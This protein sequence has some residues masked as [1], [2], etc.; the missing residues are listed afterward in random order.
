M[1]EEALS[2]EAEAVAR[3]IEAYCD[4]TADEAQLLSIRDRLDND[5][6]FA[7]ELLWTLRLR[8]LAAA[9]GARDSFEDRV[10][11]R[12][13][14]LAPSVTEE[15]VI[16]RIEKTRE[17]LPF[18]ARAARRPRLLFAAALV[19]QVLVMAALAPFLV[20]QWHPEPRPVATV[21]RAGSGEG[22]LVR[23]GERITL[24]PGLSVC[25]DDLVYSDAT[26]GA[27]L[28]WADGSRARLA[29]LSYAQLREEHGAKRFAVFSGSAQLEVK[30]QPPGAPLE[31]LTGRSRCI[32]RGTRFDI[33]ASESLTQLQV[34]SGAVEMLTRGAGPGVTVH[35]GESSLAE[36]G[37]PLHVTRTGAPVYASPLLTKDGPAGRRVAISAPLGTSRKL[38]LVVTNGA[39]NNRFDHAAWVAPRLVGPEGELDLTSVPW[40]A[41][42]SG[43]RTVIRGGFFGEKPSV[44]GRP[45]G[46]C[47]ATHATS[48]IEYD[49]PPGYERFVAEGVLLD[50]GVNQPDSCPSI[51][52]EV[53]TTIPEAKLA[54]LRVQR[55]FY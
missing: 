25:A 19:A 30:P 14:E 27:E 29:P 36:A 31:V 50:S 46:P 40:V 1:S 5:P 53:Y 54:A 52:F 7:R 9:S 15:A 28:E 17:P 37:R 44:A 51:T 38:Y 16:R 48:V 33:S 10:L 8:G 13:E 23:S 24:T 43:W 2:P 21:V 22:F 18:P 41:A 32:V 47:V 4:E 45:V 11:E 26:S 6:A 42:K 39:D 3:L 35:A 34:S 49:I 20:R 12:C 55:P